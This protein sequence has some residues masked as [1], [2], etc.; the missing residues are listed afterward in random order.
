MDVFVQMQNVRSCTENVLVQKTFN[1]EHVLL[2]C[3]VVHLSLRAYPVAHA[4]HFRDEQD[5]WVILCAISSFGDQPFGIQ[6]GPGGEKVAPL[7]PGDKGLA[8]AFV[9]DGDVRTECTNALL[10]ASLVAKAPT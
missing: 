10:L 3:V 1:A 8:I 9:G 6:T 2:T 4:R 5:D 7:K